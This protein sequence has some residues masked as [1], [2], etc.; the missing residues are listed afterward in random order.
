MPKDLQEQI[1]LLEDLFTVDTKKLKHITN[2]F[3]SELAQGNSWP[4]INQR[5]GN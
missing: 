5:Y 2:H 4:Y 3:V 1:Q